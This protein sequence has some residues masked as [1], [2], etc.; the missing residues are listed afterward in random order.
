MNGSYN[1]RYA[2]PTHHKWQAIRRVALC[3]IVQTFWSQVFH[4]KCIL[5]TME[6]IFKRCLNTIILRL[7]QCQ[8]SCQS[9]V[10]INVQVIKSA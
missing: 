10:D 1:L 4:N 8:I 5:P 6:F 9:P 3:K 2:L 7:G